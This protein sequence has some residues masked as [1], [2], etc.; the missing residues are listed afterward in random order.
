MSRD[1]GA[2]RAVG[3][4][5]GVVAMVTGGCGSGGGSARSGAGASA[6]TT[7]RVAAVTQVLTFQAYDDRGLIPGLVPAHSV[8]GSCSGGSVV[9]AGRADAWRCTAGGPVMDPCFLDEGTS[10]LACVPDPF[11]P[12]VTL[13]QVSG[14]MP[15]GNRNDPAHPAWFLELADGS[16]CGAVVADGAGGGG[17]ATAA[18]ASYACGGGTVVFGEPD[19]S[20]PV[21]RVQVGAAADPS[22]ARPA[23]VRVAWY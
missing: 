12:D 22:A 7:P 23:D 11:T 9:L 15:R 13:L 2:R 3:V 6:A 10:E 17:T 5:V 19:A 1:C 18:R 16:R 4:L 14:P 8:T 20:R 21:W